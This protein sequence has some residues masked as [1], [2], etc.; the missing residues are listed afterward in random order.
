[1][2][3]LVRRNKVCYKFWAGD[4]DVTSI[5]SQA[6]RRDPSGSHLTVPVSNSRSWTVLNSLAVILATIKPGT[7]LL[8]QLWLNNSSDT[9]SFNN[10]KGR[11]LLQEVSP[12]QD[13]LAISKAS[14]SQHS[15]PAREPGSSYNED[16]CGFPI[17]HLPPPN[18]NIQ[19]Q[20]PKGHSNKAGGTERN[21]WQNKNK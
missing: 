18:I 2:F 3:K 1:M 4:R 15:P 5:G 10:T 17:C 20:S 8:Q 12:Q 11:F 14:F 7:T 21:Q 19:L 13:R 16:V 9:R 6:H